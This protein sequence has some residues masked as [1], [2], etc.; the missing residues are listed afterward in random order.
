M[1][2]YIKEWSN[3]NSAETAEKYGF[4]MRDE[5][6][7]PESIG[8]YVR[9]FQLDT[10]LTQVN[11]LLKFIKF[12]FGQCMDHACYDIVDKKISREEGINLVRKYDGKCSS[13]Y[14]KLFCD[15]IEI[16]E[17]EFWDTA[18]KFRGN[19]WKKENNV[20]KNMIWDLF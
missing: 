15:Y 5:N 7:D 2:Y 6:F 17:K 8:T 10:D 4:K 18:E 1:N 9:Y 20:W 16:S 12:G 14:I 19:M 13:K 3:R 11:Q